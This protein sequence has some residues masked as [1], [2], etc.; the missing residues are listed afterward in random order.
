MRNSK[1]IQKYLDRQGIKIHIL[2][3]F[4]NWLNSPKPRK[5][6][7]NI[8]FIIWGIK[9]HAAILFFTKIGPKYHQFITWITRYFPFSLLFRETLLHAD[10]VKVRDLMDILKNI[11]G[12]EGISISINDGEWGRYFSI[13]HGTFEKKPKSFEESMTKLEKIFIKKYPSFY[14]RRLKNKFDVLVPT[15]II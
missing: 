5:S 9:M 12:K 15:E 13:L 14:F 10:N 3:T 6:A 1:L 4:Y 11:S 2:K 7:T 8:E